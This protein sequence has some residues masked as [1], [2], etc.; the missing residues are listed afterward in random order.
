MSRESVAG[1]AG[2]GPVVDRLVRAAR[3]GSGF[4]TVVERGPHPAIDFNSIASRSVAHGVQARFVV[5]TSA[6][7]GAFDAVGQLLEVSPGSGVADGFQHADVGLTGLQAMAA[8]FD[9]AALSASLLLVV[10]HADAVDG[11]SARVLSYLAS[12]LDARRISLLL[13]VPH[14]HLGSWVHELVA[15]HGVPQ[16]HSEDSAPP[17]DARLLQQLGDLDG[18]ARNV[19]EALAILGPGP[20]LARL[21]AVA[22]ASSGTTLD[23]LDALFSRGL[24]QRTPSG[25]GH[26]TID[27]LVLDSLSPTRRSDLH[28]RAAAQ[29]RTIGEPLEVVAAH[30]EHAA[31]GSCSWASNV[32]RSAAG[33]ALDTGDAP[34][35]VTWLQRALEEETFCGAEAPLPL[36]EQLVGAQVRADD[37]GAA[38][39]LQLAIRRSRGVQRLELQLELAR[40]LSTTG[41]LEESVAVLDD[42]IP[43]LDPSDP[44][45]ADLLLEARTVLATTC[46]LS[47]V[48]RPRSAAVLEELTADLATGTAEHAAV[49]AELAYEHSIAGTDRQVV[50]GL[51]ERALRSFGRRPPSPAGSHGLFLALVWAEDH[52]GARV[53][54]DHLHGDPRLRPLD[55]HRLGTLALAEGDLDGAVAWS[56]VAVAD[57]EWVAPLMVPGARAQLA[58]AL[59]R[60]RDLDGARAALELPGGE[61]RWRQHITFH[62]VLLAQAELALAAGDWR[63]ARARADAC[64]ELARSM[65]TLNPAVL[66]WHAA[67]ARAMIELGQLGDAGAILDAALER[68]TTF[69]APSAVTELQEVQRSLHRHRHRDGQAGD[70]EVAAPPALR[71]LR[72]ESAVTSVQLLGD[73]AVH[74]DGG[75]RRLGADLVDRA[76]CMVAIAERGVHDEQLAEALWPDGDPAA[77]RTRLRNV[78]ARVRKRYGPLLV[79]H[80][81]MVSLAQHVVVD[82]R[83]FEA[84]STEALTA[85]DPVL[86]EEAGHQALGVYGGDLCPAH[87]FEAWAAAPR[88]AVRQ[89][90]LVLVDRLIDL[91]AAR[92]D[93]GRA[94]DLFE[95]ATAVDPWNEDRYLDAVERL[96]AAGRPAAARA[97]LRRCKAMCEELGV[98]PSERQ[99]RLGRLERTDG[100]GRRL[101]AQ[102]A[103]GR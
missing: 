30:L 91:A 51:G 36:L 97:L 69:G 103:V 80:G 12:H 66:P 29:A 93:L 13:V 17:D 9:R 72:P 56:R 101:P 52:E 102:E 38:V 20:S 57:I 92:G 98:P 79:R 27:S 15:A 67:A 28:G 61:H 43:A 35:A 71:V 96:S 39:S 100:A 5:G 89:R 81:R 4:A 88:E 86:S 10:D 14:V 37:P 83:S 47:L 26:L 7:A 40:H 94:M 44:A 55:A 99:L 63:R 22:D 73:T 76:V 33:R 19:V 24:L 62:P 49:L 70:G 74:G 58:R 84:L 8:R 95:R 75:S 25:A 42:L 48:L 3:A 78:L 21:A 87:P 59:L 11:A 60:Q 45:H 77:G 23:T 1:G 34:R 41:R 65:G 90:W 82:L 6:N 18:A 64:A 54:C 68:A 32:L 46:R 31:P 50:I 16:H 2:H 53:V 85:S